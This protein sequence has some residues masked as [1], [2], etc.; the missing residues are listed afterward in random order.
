MCHTSVQNPCQCLP[1][2]QRSKCK[3][4]WLACRFVCDLAPNCHFVISHSALIWT[5]LH[6]P[7]QL[8][9]LYLFL[10]CLYP[11][12]CLS[13]F[14]SSFSGFFQVFFELPCEN[15]ICLLLTPLMWDIA[16]SLGCKVTLCLI[17]QLC[18]WLLFFLLHWKFCKGRISV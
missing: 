15:N 16:P 11:H 2:A 14:Y 9:H 1:I 13:K 18:E 10:E 7:W 4:L 8:S 17:L 12:F 5:P 3:P 6:S